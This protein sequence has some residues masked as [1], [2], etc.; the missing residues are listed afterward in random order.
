MINASPTP[1]PI[2][3]AFVSEDPAWYKRAVFYEVLVRGF[4][5]SNGDG[6]GDLRGAHREAR[7]SRMAR[8]RLPVAAA[9]VRVAAA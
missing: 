5:D 3:E 4:K 9:V 2:S 8:R 7:L 6:T 1:E